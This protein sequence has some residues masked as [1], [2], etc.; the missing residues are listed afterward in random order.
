M[1]MTADSF[2]SSAADGLIQSIPMD[3]FKRTSGG[4]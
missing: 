2:S 1:A 3:F 4:T